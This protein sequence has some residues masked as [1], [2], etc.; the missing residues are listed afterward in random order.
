MTTR[1][2]RVAAHKAKITRDIRTQM[3]RGED[4]RLMRHKISETKMSVHKARK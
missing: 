2:K 1:T 3:A 4:K